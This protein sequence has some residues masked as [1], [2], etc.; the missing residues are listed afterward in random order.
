MAAEMLLK[1]TDDM[2]KN[3][4]EC[5]CMPK[6]MIVDDNEFNIF[7]IKALIISNFKVEVD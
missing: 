1:L 2:R 5:G 4:A 6:V 3:V 7:P